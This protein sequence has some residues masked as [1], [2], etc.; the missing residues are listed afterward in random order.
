MEGRSERGNEDVEEKEDQ[1]NKI[2]RFSG[3]V[4]AELRGW[5]VQ[6]ALKLV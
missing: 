2:A 6:L 1:G 5:K 3:E 4:R